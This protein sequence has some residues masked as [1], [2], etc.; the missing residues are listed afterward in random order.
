MGEPHNLFIREDPRE[1]ARLLKVLV[2][3][4]TFDRG[5]LSVAWLKPFDRFARGNENGDWRG[6]WDELRNDLLTTAAYTRAF[7]TNLL[8][9]FTCASCWLLTMRLRARIRRTRVS[10]G[11]GTVESN[12]SMKGTVDFG[13]MGTGN[14]SGSRKK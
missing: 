9:D 8:V 2:S 7:L 6:V 5:G 1:R 12:D 10:M 11:R 13:G 14:W 4:S 3:N